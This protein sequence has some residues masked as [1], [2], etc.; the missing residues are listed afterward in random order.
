MLNTSCTSILIIINY[1]LYT[2]LLLIKYTCVFLFSHLFKNDDYYYCKIY[3]FRILFLLF[4]KYYYYEIVI[5]YVHL[6]K[7][8]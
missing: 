8:V 5:I 6:T 7:Y 3:M 1:L 2:L 4:K